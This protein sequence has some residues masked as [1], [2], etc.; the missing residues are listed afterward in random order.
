MKINVKVFANAKIQSVEEQPDKSFN[1]RLKAK[2]MAGKANEELIK[3]LAQYFRVPQSKLAIK[4]GRRS[5]LK[6]LDIER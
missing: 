3:V 2:P 1:I 6:L 4:Q 5:K